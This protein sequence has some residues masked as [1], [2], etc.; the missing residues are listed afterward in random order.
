MKKKLICIILAV[1][2]LSSVIALTAV[3]AED[4]KQ[5][6]SSGN[7]G[8][9]F[10]LPTI[11][12][13]QNVTARIIAPS[14]KTYSAKRLELTE[15]GQY[16]VEYYNSNGDLVETKYC[17]AIRRST[18]MFT[19]NNYATI[20]GIDKYKYTNVKNLTGVKFEVSTGASITLEREIDMTNRTQKDVLTSIVI[21]PT[22]APQQK[23]DETVYSRDFGRMILTYTDV[24]DP[25]VY[26]TVITTTG[27]QDTKGDGGRAYVRAG[28][29]G[30]LAGG[31][32]EKNGAYSFN[33]TDIYGARAPFSF[34]A[35]VLHNNSSNYE[36]A[37]KLCYDSEEN[38]LYLANGEDNLYG[39]PYRIVD[40]DE[41]SNFGTN[42]WTGFPSGRAKL[43]VTFDYFVNKTGNIIF[44]EADGIDF[45]QENLVD[46]Q[47]PEI[48]VD[49]GGETSAPNSYVGAT[50][51]IF[52]A[53]ATDF[54]DLA[55]KVSASVYYVDGENR[56]DVNVQNGAF[57]TNRVGKYEIVYTTTDKSGNAAT[58]TIELYCVRNHNDITFKDIDESMDVSVFDTVNL[59]PADDV[60]CVGGNGELTRSLTVYSPTNEVVQLIDN[61]F[62]PT[63][64]G[65]YR[66]EYKATDFFGEKGVAVININV[67]ATDQPIFV[68]KISLPDVLINGFTYNF[69][70]VSAKK[71]V[72]GAVVDAPVKYYVD[73]K[74]VT[75]GKFTVDATGII[76]VECRTD[77]KDGEPITIYK[78]VYVVD[79]NKGLDQQN[80][81]YSADG[82]VTSGLEKDYVAL[83]AEADGT[84]SFA[85]KLGNGQFK[86][87]FSYLPTQIGFSS[88]D[89][90]LSSANDTS[91]SVTFNVTFSSMGLT[92][93]TK[94]LS[95]VNFS[96]KNDATNNYFAIGYTDAT[97]TFTDVNDKAM[98]VLKSYDDGTEF[99]G[100]DG[101]IYLSIKFNSVKKASQ[102]FVTAINNQ[103]FGYKYSID[104]PAGD[105]NGPQIIINGTY[106]RR[107]DL[108][109][110]LTVYTA[111]AYDVL[112]QVETFTLSVYDPDNVA[113][114]S[115]VS[116]DKIYT[117]KLDKIGRYRIVYSAK[118]T[119]GNNKVTNAGTTLTVVDIVEPTLEVNSKI[120]ELYAVGSK[121]K[122]PKFTVSD[123]TE[124]V[125]CDVYLLLPNNETRLLLSYVN[126]ETTSYLVPS[127]TNYPS[128]FKA[129]ET[130]FYAETA[131][132]YVL[133]YLAYDDSFNYVRHTIEF[134]VVEKESK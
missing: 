6:P 19:T 5:I 49:M 128:S 81:F 131:G 118:D 126:G 18:D 57:V 1:A 43:T 99:N 109:S 132:T 14:G 111:D 2:L 134:T 29:N 91:K 8:D 3:F 96:L 38:A 11:V 103:S 106:N 97:H 77:G 84:T 34:Q 61:A 129:G 95:S 42:I 28:G 54:F 92:V 66:A 41:V 35:E 74:E 124:N 122:L 117:V 56:I 114:L 25:S 9:K 59:T 55:T 102:L 133:T 105:I 79:G 7:L 44:T 53:T 31:Y 108:G 71:V 47:A 39:K 50:Y 21:E 30:Q 32:E 127:D 48:T 100:F 15:I 90:I 72:S 60:R 76:R 88:I 75:D 46:D 110:T 98:C 33:T 86:V 87:S 70:A 36:F 89:V 68:G 27:N 115:N 69:P 67:G 116:P 82:S 113:I 51:K 40:F 12:D 112:N 85:N 16:T 20:K 73:E 37:L 58:K 4:S 120:K 26:F 13:G 23:D 121:I 130:S 119:S 125:Y 45:S 64:I 63:T 104:D 10:D 83:N 17:V 93:A 24:E 52:D 22:T 94:D 107:Q 78:D 101:G 62:I 65:V 123:N 80:Y